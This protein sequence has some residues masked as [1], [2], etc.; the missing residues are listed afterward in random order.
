MFRIEAPYP[1]VASTTLLP[2][3]QQ[4]NNQSLLSQVNVVRMMDGS[5]R[6]FVKKGGGK[7]LHRWDFTV[8][9]DKME[10][11]TDFVERYRSST[12]R[13]VWR[14][15]SLIGK[16]TLNPTEAQGSGRAGG[17]PGGEAYDLTIELIEV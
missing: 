15:R 1:A 4:G 12:C 11:M 13:V 16:L 10:E 17:W 2:S 9:R 8:S 3:P 7:R 14:G 5:R 6:T